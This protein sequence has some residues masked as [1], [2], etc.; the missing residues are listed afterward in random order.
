MKTAGF[1]QNS[2]LPG[3][4][5]DQGHNGKATSDCGGSSAAERPQQVVILVLDHLEGLKMRNS[6]F[7]NRWSQGR[8]VGDVDA[9]TLL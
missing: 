1:L 4:E 8:K 5:A 7:V 6:F 3:V 2:V 9:I